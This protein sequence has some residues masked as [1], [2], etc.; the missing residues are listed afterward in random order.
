MDGK[1]LAK[2]AMPILGQALLVFGST[3]AAIWAYEKLRSVKVKAPSTASTPPAT[4]PA[5]SPTV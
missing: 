5:S 4:A 1:S 3:L 2:K